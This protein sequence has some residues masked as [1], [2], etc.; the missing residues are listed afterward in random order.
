MIIST[1]VALLAFNTIICK[2]DTLSY[3]CYDAYVED[4][5]RVSFLF[6]PKRLL[7]EGDGH[8]EDERVCLTQFKIDSNQ[9]DTTYSNRDNRHYHYEIVFGYYSLYLGKNGSEEATSIKDMNDYDLLDNYL[10]YSY[11]DDAMLY[12]SLNEDTSPRLI[13]FTLVPRKATS[14]TIEILTA[15]SDS[16]CDTLFVKT[17]HLDYISSRFG[18]E[19]RKRLLASMDYRFEYADS[20]FFLEVLDERIMYWAYIYSPDISVYQPWLIEKHSGKMITRHL[21]EVHSC[22]KMQEVIYSEKKSLIDKEYGHWS[23]LFTFLLFTKNNQGQF[24]VARY[25]KTKKTVLLF[26]PKRPI[27]YL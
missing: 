1:I 5:C 15:L 9:R 6:E 26:L 3:V 19:S 21:F 4:T 12:Y 22:H 16:L 10:Y 7:K 2:E 25:E 14:Q 20:I 27:T 13:L 11:K 23:N 17:N 8:T 24:E 18:A